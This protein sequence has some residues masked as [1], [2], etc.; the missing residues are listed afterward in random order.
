MANFCTLI[1]KN[2][3]PTHPNVKAPAKS[4]WCEDFAAAVTFGQNGCF[5]SVMSVQNCKNI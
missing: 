5:G 2:A 4:S 1:D 3:P